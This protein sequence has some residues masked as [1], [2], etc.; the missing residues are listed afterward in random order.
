MQVWLW[1]IDQAIKLLHPS[2]FP[3]KDPTR[4]DSLLRQ[5][6]DGFLVVLACPGNIESLI[7][8][9]QYAFLFIVLHLEDSS[10]FLVRKAVLAL[11]DTRRKAREDGGEEAG[12]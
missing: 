2:P 11:S 7:L 9:T 10:L 1:P 5:M 6:I 4:A 3:R 12:L 8:T